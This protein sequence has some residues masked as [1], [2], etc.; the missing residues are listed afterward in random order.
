MRLH[1]LRNAKVHAA[2]GEA[3]LAQSSSSSLSSR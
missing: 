3:L 1:A 2:D